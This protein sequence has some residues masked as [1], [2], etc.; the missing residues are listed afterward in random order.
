M[1]KDG[2]FDMEEAQKHMTNTVKD[3]TWNTLLQQS[4]TSCKNTISEHLDF[5]QS[6]AS[7]TKSECD[8]FFFHL[9]RCISIVAFTVSLSS[10]IKSSRFKKK[11]VVDVPGD[12]K[13]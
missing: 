2:S 9:P 3:K 11:F 1:I 5:L 4:L 8:V 10:V 6:K 13:G 12:L 7:F